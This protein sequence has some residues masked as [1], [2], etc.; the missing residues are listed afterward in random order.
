MR[1]KWFTAMVLPASVLAF[2]S[3]ASAAAVD[4]TNAT[5]VCNTFLKGGAKF[6]PALNAVALNTC[7]DPI[8]LAPRTETISI[9]GTI[10]DCTVTGAGAV[11]VISGSVKGTIYTGDCSCTGL[12]APQPFVAPPAGKFNQLVTSWKFDT[13]AAD[14]CMPGQKAS[15][16]NLATGGNVT[17]GPFIA[18]AANP[19]FGASAIY[20]SFSLNPP[21]VTGVT[22]I[23]QGGDAG[24]TSTTSGATSESLNS[25]FT[26]CAG[27]KGLKGITFGQGYTDLK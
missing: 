23:F 2:C 15:T 8:T 21:T 4:C 6:K 11:K 12:A 20:G 22:G 17:S 10:S 18:S 16:L 25:L 13:T 5:I 1:R 14:V 3:L 24:A 19:N 7:P 26:T 27:P 9:K